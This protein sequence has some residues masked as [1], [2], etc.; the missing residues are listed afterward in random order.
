MDCDVCGMSYDDADHTECEVD[1]DY[2]REI[3]QN[4]QID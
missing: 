4:T 2:N 1:D 3:K